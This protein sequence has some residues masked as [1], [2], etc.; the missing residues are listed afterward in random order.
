[1]SMYNLLMG[2]R[3]ETSAWLR[4][5]GFLTPEAV[6][7]LRDAYVTLVG[8][9]PRIVVFTRNG[10]GNRGC[11]QAEGCDE[12]KG[13]HGRMCLVFVNASLQKHPM[14]V[15]DWDDD[16]DSTYASFEFKVP[17]EFKELVVEYLSKEGVDAPPMERFRRLIDKMK[18]G[19]ESDPE[20]KVALE[21]GRPLMERLSKALEDGG[22]TVTV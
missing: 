7:R 2:M 4:V 12:L 3:A 19:D 22:G 13:T 18:T 8:D 17:P 15:Q 10:G 1:M 11:W 16:F 14:Y 5:L 21:K 9:E 20:V 6:G